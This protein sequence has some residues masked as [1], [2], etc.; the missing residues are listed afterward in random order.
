MKEL[1]QKAGEGPDSGWRPG[2][3]AVDHRCSTDERN[4]SQEHSRVRSVLVLEMTK[5][6]LASYQAAVRVSAIGLIPTRALELKAFD[7][8]SKPSGGLAGAQ[9]DT[10]EEMK[11]KVDELKM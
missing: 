3:A 4:S 7:E 11:A 1:D 10:V 9:Q 5:A 8:K 2:E 6:I